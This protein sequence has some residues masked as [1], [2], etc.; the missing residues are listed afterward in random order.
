MAIICT[1]CSGTK[2]VKMVFGTKA[3]PCPACKAT[4]YIS[5]DRV[6]CPVCEGGKSF[7][8]LGG[9]ATQTCPYCSG[10]GEVN[11]SKIK[12]DVEQNYKQD[13]KVEEAKRDVG[14]LPSDSNQTIG[15][16]V[17]ETSPV[18]I[19]NDNLQKRKGGRKSAKEVGCDESTQ[20]QSGE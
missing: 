13:S 10:V 12:A 2:I 1:T 8:S 17:G 14:T 5:M 20:K 16:K 15:S 18:G 9:M 7:K 4:G 6:R 19:S 3:I 11:E